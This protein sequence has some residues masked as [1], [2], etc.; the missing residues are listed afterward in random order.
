[1]LCRG[2][3]LVSHLRD[4]PSAARVAAAGPRPASLP[5]PAGTARP[6]QCGHGRA[7]SGAAPLQASSPLVPAKV[8]QP[9]PSRPP[10]SPYRAQ[11]WSSTSLGARRTLA[12]SITLGRQ[13]IALSYRTG[14]GPDRASVN[15]VSKTRWARTS[16]S[17]F[18]CRPTQRW[19]IHPDPDNLA[20]LC[21]DIDR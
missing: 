20:A 13:I 1:M 19:Q 7:P 3:N 10:W 16:P 6:G 4:V 9:R 15:V 18:E 8:G 12:Q 14:R 17:A 2:R 5:R 11:A 21:V